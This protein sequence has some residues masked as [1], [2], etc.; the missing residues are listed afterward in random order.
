MLGGVSEHVL[1]SEEAVAQGRSH[2][3]YIVLI[4]SRKIV[5]HLKQGC[6]IEAMI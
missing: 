6:R 5:S 1:G 2:Q 4:I 3:A